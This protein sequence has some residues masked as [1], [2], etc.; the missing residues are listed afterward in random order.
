MWLPPGRQQ[1]PKGIT[2]LAIVPRTKSVPGERGW[3]SCK[4]TPPRQLIL[5]LGFS[6][7]QALSSLS[8]SLAAERCGGGKGPPTGTPLS[9][10]IPS[11]GVE[12]GEGDVSRGEGKDGEVRIPPPALDVGA[13]TLPTLQMR[14]V[15][16]RARK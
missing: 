1:L 3:P 4:A 7:L 10:H 2:D 12:I 8:G 6:Q 16:L 15:G 5:Y 11:D 9:P 14:E 13:A